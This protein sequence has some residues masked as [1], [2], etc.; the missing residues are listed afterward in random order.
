[1]T[2]GNYITKSSSNLT[3][4]SRGLVVLGDDSIQN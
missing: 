2:H 1:M 4:D 3:A